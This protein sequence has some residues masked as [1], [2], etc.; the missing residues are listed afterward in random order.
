MESE[1]ATKLRQLVWIFV[2]T[3]DEVCTSRVFQKLGRISCLGK[4]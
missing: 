2:R 3:R 4:K 1:M